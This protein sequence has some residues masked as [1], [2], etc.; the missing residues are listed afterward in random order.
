MLN[1]WLINIATMSHS[2]IR[3]KLFQIVAELVFV[4]FKIVSELSPGAGQ[5][6]HGSLPSWSFLGMNT[7]TDATADGTEACSRF[8]RGHALLDDK[9]NDDM[10]CAGWR[11]WP[12]HLLDASIH[13]FVVVFFWGGKS[14]LLLLHWATY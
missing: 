6:V 13:Y 8:I 9:E 1:P 4:L 10:P 12:V 7:V 5:S 3:L 14:S 2:N 11:T